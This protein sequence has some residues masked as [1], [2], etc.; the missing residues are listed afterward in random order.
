MLLVVSDV[1]FWTFEVSLPALEVG[2]LILAHWRFVTPVVVMEPEKL[3]VVEHDNIHVVHVETLFAESHGFSLLAI[4][5]RSSSLMLNVEASQ[6][7][8]SFW[9]TYELQTLAHIGSHS[10]KTSILRL[11]GIKGSRDDACT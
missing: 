1:K 4:A 8:H 2:E 7:A 9:E 6:L 5:I 10:F 3:L 11:N